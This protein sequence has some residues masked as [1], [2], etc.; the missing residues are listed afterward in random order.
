MKQ[1]NGLLGE[2]KVMKASIAKVFQIAIVSTDIVFIATD[3]EKPAKFFKVNEEEL[4]AVNAIINE[5]G[6]IQSCQNSQKFN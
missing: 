1:I 6:E 5:L 3:P 2:F 4:K